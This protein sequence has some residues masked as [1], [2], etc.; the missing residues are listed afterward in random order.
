MAGPG[1]KNERKW[2]ALEG[3]ERLAEPSI[4]QRL[5]SAAEAVEFCYELG[6]DVGLLL[7]RRQ[8][9]GQETRLSGLLLRRILTDLRAVWILCVKGYTSQAGVLCT[10]LFENALAAE[11]V[12]N[13]RE[14]AEEVI[15]APGGELPWSVKELVR[16]VAEHEAG[17]SGVEGQASPIESESEYMYFTYR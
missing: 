2:Q 7:A 10:S 11:L 1:E 8:E 3:M 15:R 5:R 13:S 14:L 16:R 4:S 6:V 12:A 17:A 9:Q